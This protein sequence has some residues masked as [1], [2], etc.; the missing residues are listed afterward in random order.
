VIDVAKVADK[1][2]MELE[3]GMVTETV[4]GKDTVRLTIKGE[5]KEFAWADVLASKCAVCAFP[6]AVID[7]VFVGEKREGKSDGFK[8]LETF[9]SMSLE[10]RFAFWEKEMSRCIR[11][12]A[13][14]NA[15]PLC[16][17]RDHCVATSRDPHWLSQADSTRD[18]FFFQL[19]HA[20][21]LA[22]RCTG[23]GECV[24][25]CPMNIPV[26]LFKRAM[27]RATMELFGYAAGVEPEGVPPLQTF[28]IEEPTIK[29]RDW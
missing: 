19:I 3:A 12:Y 17:C 21:H 29:E 20:T 16:V 27:G 1:L 9:E 5:S 22:G 26:G 14:R 25:A 28:Q 4:I 15:C 11:C 13:C 6:N 10:E 2:G 8:D 24:R 23:C 18:K 7:D